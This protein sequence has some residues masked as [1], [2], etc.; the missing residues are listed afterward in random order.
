M[1]CSMTRARRNVSF[2]KYNFDQKYRIENV[3]VLLE[4]VESISLL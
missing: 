2:S 3:M 1:V 4:A